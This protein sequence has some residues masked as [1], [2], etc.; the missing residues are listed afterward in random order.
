MGG[1]SGQ[2][3]GAEQALPLLPCTYSCSL[4][5]PFPFPFPFPFLPGI[6][7]SIILAIPALSIPSVYIKSQCR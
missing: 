2:V 4:L 3:G 1:V 5:I 6:F 7:S